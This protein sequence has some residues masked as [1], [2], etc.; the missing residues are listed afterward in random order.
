MNPYK[1]CRWFLAVCLLATFS[2]AQVPSY[3][4]H[5]RSISELQADQRR[6]VSQWCRLDWEGSR[7]NADGWKKFDPL[8]TLK[9]NPDYNSIYVV[10]RYEMLPPERVSMESTVS[11]TVIGRYEPGIGFT[12]DPESR[13]VTFKFSDKDSDLQITGLE[14]AQPNVSKPVF[15]NWLKAQLATAKTPADKLPLQ[16]ALDQLVP[17]PPPK[18]KTDEGSSS[19]KP[20]L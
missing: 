3:R 10:S 2:F 1:F 12:A 5:S 8:T 6:L 17:P 11:Y 20:R 14:P 16:S 15:I 9:L 18:P 13:T 7:L 19:S 4:I